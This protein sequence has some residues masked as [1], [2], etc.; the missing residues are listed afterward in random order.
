M[1]L[2]DIINIAIG[3]MGVYVCYVVLRIFLLTRA[4]SVLIL[5]A[6]VLWAVVL[7]LIIVGFAFKH[8]FFNATV[9]MLGFWLP[10]TIGMYSLLRTLRK[11]IK[12]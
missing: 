11:Y 8:E 9:L 1:L 6:G 4:R 12:N 2:N 7:R 3:V 10:F 5:L